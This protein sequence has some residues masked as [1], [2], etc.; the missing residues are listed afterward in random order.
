[1]L[2]T[3]E[4]LRMSWGE[5]CV[6]DHRVEF[7]IR[8]S[9]GEP[10]SVLCREYEISRPTGYLWLHRFRQEGVAG[11]EERSHRPHNSPGRTS[12]ILEQRIAALRAERPDWGAR[13]LAELL[14]REAT[15]LPVVTIHRVL[16]RLGLVSHPEGRRHA[17]KRFERDKPNQLW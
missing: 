13:K 2:Y 16:R 11:I 6:K 17:T 14:A 12:T 3:I 1:M 7:V 10:I 4:V 5:M 9:R 15:P 8:A